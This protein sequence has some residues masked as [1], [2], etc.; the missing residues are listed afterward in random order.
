MS[1]PLEKPIVVFGTG[2][3]GT[4]II[5]EA[6]F[7][8]PDLAYPSNYDEKFPGNSN[9]GYIRRF[10]DNPLWRYEGKKKQLN[11][12][13][14]INRYAF[15]P[16]ESYAMWE[17]LCQQ[18]VDFSRGFLL[19]DRL[20]NSAKVEARKFFTNLIKAQGRKRLALKITGPARIGF[21]TDIFPDALFIQINR[22]PISTIKSWLKVDFWQEKGMNQLWWTGAYSKEELAWVKENSN[23]P[24][25]LAALQ[26]KTLIDSAKEEQE[27]LAAPVLS[28]SYEE[29][30][31]NS[32]DEIHKMIHFCGLQWSTWIDKYMEN[33]PIRLEERPD[34]AF[35]SKDEL[36]EIY[37]VLENGI[38]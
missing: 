31:R 33:N 18:E 20:S 11:D 35:F 24:I 10:F 36:R 8:H 27:A 19:S 38:E 3:S 34:E 16:G 23:S 1:H 9:T 32:I 30:T 25:K 5:S 6:L 37:H 14:L 21:L 12:T 15:M 28:I 2:R 26:Y 4:T 17:S 7:R 29:F 13:G 22:K